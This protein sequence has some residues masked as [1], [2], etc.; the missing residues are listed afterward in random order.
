MTV[1]EQKFME[2]VPMYLNEIAQELKKLN[3]NIEKKKAG[4]AFFKTEKH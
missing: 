2:L 3:E 1:L 4:Q